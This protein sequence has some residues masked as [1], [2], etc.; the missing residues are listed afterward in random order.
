[1]DLNLVMQIVS[2]YGF[3]ALIAIYLIFRHEQMIQKLNES[4]ERLND[5]L[6]KFE[7]E[8][9]RIKEKVKELEGKD[10]DKDN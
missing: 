6:I 1:M 5:T 4:V 7:Y 9:N 10:V 2:N 3:P 8:L